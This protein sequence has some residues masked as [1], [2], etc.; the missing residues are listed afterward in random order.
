MKTYLLISCFLFSFCYTKSEEWIHFLNEPY[1]EPQSFF[2]DGND[3]IVANYGENGIWTFDYINWTSVI[4]D[5]SSIDLK[6]NSK[7]YPM[8]NG[9]IILLT[10]EQIDIPF[11]VVSGINSYYIIQNGILREEKE[12]QRAA[13]IDAVIDSTYH[14]WL[15]TYRNSTK[16]IGTTSLSKTTYFLERSNNNIPFDMK[17]LLYQHSNIIKWEETS[18]KHKFFPYIAV[19]SKNHL[20]IGAVNQLFEYDLNKNILES[21]NEFGEVVFESKRTDLIEYDTIY[22]NNF[23]KLFIDLYDNVIFQKNGIIYMFNGSE[24]IE[25]AGKNIHGFS[26]PSVNDIYFCENGDKWF[27]TQ[28]DGI[29]KWSLVDNWEIFKSELTELPS[30]TVY[31]IEID[32]RKNVWIH[33]GKGISVYRKGGVILSAE[34]E[35]RHSAKLMLS[36]HPNPF[37]Q[38]TIINYEL[39]EAGYIS[40]EL[41]DMLGNKIATLVDDWQEAGTHSCRFNGEGLTAGVYLVRMTSG[42]GVVTEKVIRIE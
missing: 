18:N 26:F 14:I 21:A 41:F 4:K 37:S 3:N 9:S 15:T 38:S 31:N 34:D 19:D 11:S 27:A 35:P 42:E 13:L 25:I 12:L 30:D 10:S 7:I 1:L 33:H 22:T 5:Y 16:V 20:W 39:R 23:N 28:K 29:Y 24:I 6:K 2:I 17:E 40:L 32:S 36:A 8:R